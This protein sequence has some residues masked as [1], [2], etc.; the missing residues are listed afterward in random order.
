MGDQSD[1]APREGLSRRNLI[2]R[3]LRRPERSRGPPPSCSRAWHRPQ[4]R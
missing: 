4:E 3:V 2:K 1:S